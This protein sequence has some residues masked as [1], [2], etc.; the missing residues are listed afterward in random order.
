MG[1]NSF[2]EGVVTLGKLIAALQLEDEAR[3]LPLGFTTPHS[4]RG[5]YSELAFSLAIGR[6]AG[7]SLA[8]ARA[9]LGATFDGYKGGKYAMDADTPV[10]VGNYGECGILLTRTRL[11]AMLEAPKLGRLLCSRCLG[12]GRDREASDARPN[13]QACEGSGSVS[14][15][16]D[17]KAALAARVAEGET[18]LSRSRKLIDELQQLVNDQGS[19]LENQV[20]AREAA[21]LARIKDLEEG[22]SFLRRLRA[23]NV[24]R[25]SEIP[26]FV[27]CAR[28]NVLEWA[29]AMCGEAGEFANVAKKLVRDDEHDIDLLLELGREAADVVIYLDLA[30]A[31]VGFDLEDLVAEKFD[32]VSDQHSWTGPRFNP[33]KYFA[34]APF[35][36]AKRESGAEG[37]T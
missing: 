5:D 23:L 8:A 31:K 9:A 17:E 27:P 2:E 36:N 13:C 25:Q 26:K 20:V 18:L 29:G 28:W 10:L 33:G 12:D 3:I 37:G 30:L 32:L 7:A 16:I 14:P 4:D 6:S 24:R 19:Y 1:I 11:E 21:L 22:A 34:G 15:A 35:E